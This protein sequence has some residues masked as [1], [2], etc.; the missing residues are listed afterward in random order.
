M[1]GAV[2]RSDDLALVTSSI[3][4]P[5]VVLAPSFRTNCAPNSPG[6]VTTIRTSFEV[7]ETHI[8]R[9]YREI[10]KPNVDSA[11]HF[12]IST[13]QQ[14]AAKVQVEKPTAGFRKMRAGVTSAFFVGAHWIVHAAAIIF[15]G[16]EPLEYRLLEHRGES[17]NGCTLSMIAVNDVLDG[18][19]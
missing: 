9:L 3:I 6:G 10:Q 7:G 12:V 8:A 5:W 16:G 17:P 15:D 1:N 2:R 18:L 14:S 19:R 11:K 13:E 4:T